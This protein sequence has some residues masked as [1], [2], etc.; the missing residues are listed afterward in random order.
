MANVNPEAANSDQEIILFWYDISIFSRKMDYYLTLRGIPYRR[1]IQPPNMPRPGLQKL[2]IGYRR[3]PILAIGRNIYCDTRLIIEKLE[4]LY[5]DKPKLGSDVPFERGLEK[6]FEGWVIE[7]GPFW[8]TAG[9]M[10]LSS[11]IL[12]DPVWMKDRFDIS[13]GRFTAENLRKGQA[14]SLANLRLYFGI[15]EN[16]MADGR[17]WVLGGDKVSLADVHLIWTF[18]WAIHIGTHADVENVGK[19]VLNDK[20]FPC[21]FAW[22]ERFRQVSQALEFKHGAAPCL[23]SE[24][25]VEEI[26]KS[27]LSEASL[28]VD[29]NE[30]LGLSKDQV[31][32]VAPTEF[33]FQHRDVGVLSGLDA[34]EV[35]IATTVP[36]DGNGILR[37]HF[38]RMNYSIRAAEV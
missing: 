5:V 8:K 6:V 15:A 24:D 7:G 32:E 11:P 28:I 4:T 14:E 1:C 19:H 30:S 20:A 22:V 9:C 3:I 31:V 21:T 16:L 17:Q 25:G 36:G 18:D 27:R 29:A 13:G 34:G 33:N 35:I 12:S 38:P 2:G 37:L 23:S 10:P 26:L